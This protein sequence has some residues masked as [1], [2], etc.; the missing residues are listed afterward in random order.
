MVLDEVD[1]LAELRLVDGRAGV[2]LAQHALEARVLALDRHH[3]VVD[4][5][6]DL[7]LLGVGLQVAPARLARHPE[8]VLGGVAA[9]RPIGEPIRPRGLL[10]S[11]GRPG[12]LPLRWLRPR[13]K[14]PPRLTATC[15][16]RDT[17]R[18]ST[19]ERRTAA[20][21][22]YEAPAAVRLSVRI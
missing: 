6:A 11:G 7:G 5:L 9:G 8:D 2:V 10:L 13:L 1:E 18:A 12:W 17:T 4:E 20:G 19:P 16:A 14:S 3:G 21:A 15:F 22:S